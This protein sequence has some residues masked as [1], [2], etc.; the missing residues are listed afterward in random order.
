MWKVR[1]SLVAARQRADDFARSAAR[2]SHARGARRRRCGPRPR[3]TPWSSRRRSCWRR[4]ARPCRCG[5]SPASA[6]ARCG[7]ADDS[8]RRRMK[9][10]AAGFAIEQRATSTDPVMVLGAG[11]HGGRCCECAAAKRRHDS[12]ATAGTPR[13]WTFIRCRGRSPGSQV[14]VVRP[15]FPMRMCASVTQNRTQLSA[16]SCGGSAG[17][18]ALLARPPASLLATK[19]CDHGGP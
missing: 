5:G 2:R 12:Q 15:V 1:P 13:P 17:F 4:T 8:G 16:Y 6:A 3:E 11:C 19:S 14:V 10:A 9:G 18:H 7:V